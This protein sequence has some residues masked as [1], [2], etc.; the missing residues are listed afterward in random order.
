MGKEFKPKRVLQVLIDFGIGGAENWTRHLL[1]YIDHDR[2]EI[3]FLVHNERSEY[4]E[5]VLKFGGR[6]IY[7]PY[8]FN[9]WSYEHRFKGFLRQYGPYDIIHS[10]ISSVGFHLKWASQLGIPVRI[11]QCHIDDT[12]E[13][14]HSKILRR[15]AMR[16]SQYL[17]N[18]YATA[19][20]AVSQ[21]AAK[22]FGPHWAS[23]PRWRI[24]YCGIDL[25]PFE[26][27]FDRRKIREELG[28]PADAF[29]VGHVGRIGYQKN[30]TFALEVL[31]SMIKIRPD[32]YFVSVGEGDLRP[33]LEQKASQLG[34]TNNVIFLGRRH[35]VPRL[36]KGAMDRFLLPSFF[37]GL[38]LVLMETQAA[39][40]PAVI[41]DTI[42]E[43]ADVIKP[44]I[45]RLSLHDSPSLWAHELIAPQ[46]HK[47]IITQ[48]Q[49]LEIMER[50]KFNI[51]FSCDSL[52]IL[53]SQLS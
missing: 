36:M 37:E 38:P 40:L 19:G 49:A 16:I 6:I 26:K 25:E 31:S 20:I 30:L 5:D 27:E 34:L 10:Q 32:T 53:Y 50:S 1:R 7:C 21:Q 45:S 44:L 29:V 28:I 41:A 46:Q 51:K 14:R 39:A 48:Y 22:R 35:D 2:F 12:L 43:E 42:T 4:A 52:M 9:P 17:T 8:S 24:L 13:L 47:E 23:D 18:R 3:D 33:V 15:V 11:V